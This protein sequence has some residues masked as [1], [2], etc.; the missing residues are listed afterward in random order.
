MV[1]STV[2]YTEGQIVNQVVESYQVVSLEKDGLV[3]DPLSEGRTVEGYQ[4]A[5][6]EKDGPVD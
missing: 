4:S 2:R 1:Q 6:L 3:D 5:F